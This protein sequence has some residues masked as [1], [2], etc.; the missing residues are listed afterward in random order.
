MKNIMRYLNKE[1]FEWL[2]A[3]KGLY[4]SSAEDQSDRDEGISDHT[5]LA[6]HIAKT[7]KDVEPTL[8]TQLDELMLDLQQ[9]GRE[10]NYLSCW[11]LGTEETEAM[12]EEFG[13]GGVVLF[14]Q[15]WVMMYAFSEPLEHA[16]KGYPVTYSDDLKAAALHEPLRVKHKKFTTESEFRAV[17]S[18]TEYS[19]LTGFESTELYVGDQLS[20]KSPEII[21]CMSKK[22]IEQAMKV[23]R[24]KGRGLVL[25]FDF[26]RAIHEVRMHPLATDEELLHVQSRLLEIDVKCPVRHSR[27]RRG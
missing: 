9:V 4:L 15:E 13:K 23:I 7:V 25:D 17:F 22:G 24:R 11:Y 10:K 19:L 26:G 2:L 16:M 6:K 12:W 8:L 20:H 5:F 14:S 3:D 21:K 27:L 18:L 1:K